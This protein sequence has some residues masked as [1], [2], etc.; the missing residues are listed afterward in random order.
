MATKAK[1]APKAAATTTK[2]SLTKTEKAAATMSYNEGR[3]ARERGNPRDSCLDEQ[4]HLREAW[5]RGWDEADQTEDSVDE[6]NRMPDAETE[7]TTNIIPG[8]LREVPIPTSNG[9]NFNDPTV[10]EHGVKLA[11]LMDA[12]DNIGVSIEEVAWRGLSAEQQNIAAR[13]INGRRNGS[14]TSCPEFLMPF[15]TEK[16]KAEFTDYLKDQRTHRRVVMP[17]QFEKP[18]PTKPEGDD[19][20]EKIKMTF[21]VPVADLS[22]S[23]ANDLWGYRRSRVEFG[24]LKVNEW[25]QIELPGAEQTINVIADISGFSRNRT[26]WKFACFVPTDLLSI[27]S[28]FD[29]WKAYGSLRVEC[30]GDIP[31][32]DRPESENPENDAD[33][34][35]EPD[36]VK[37]PT[38]FRDDDSDDDTAADAPDEYLVPLNVAGSSCVLFSWKQRGRFFASFN[39]VFDL[40]GETFDIGE[41]QL[42]QPFGDGCVTLS[43]ALEK[44]LGQ[45]IDIGTTD[46]APSDVVDQMKDELNRISKGGLPHLMPKSDGC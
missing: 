41:G 42:Y 20:E 44:A 28:A 43:Q 33:D 27:V 39:L 9:H 30:L 12:F 21:K 3:Q 7:E 45:A 11:D 46:G 16:L 18:S 15:A 19:S 34:D 23:T 10:I 26:H 40:D 1:S 36:E 4:P 22:A 31:K 17:C 32:D 25:D 24:T 6:A 29:L 35:E 5:F 38:L 2:K 13:W 8:E 14:S 37:Q